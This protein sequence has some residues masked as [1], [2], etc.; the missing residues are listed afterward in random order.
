MKK[1][2][3]YNS[4][5]FNQREERRRFLFYSKKMFNELGFSNK[6]KKSFLFYIRIFSFKL[7]LYYPIRDYVIDKI[8]SAEQKQKIVTIIKRI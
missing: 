1:H 5:E 7:K 8:F 3:D 4:I 6:Q 2:Y